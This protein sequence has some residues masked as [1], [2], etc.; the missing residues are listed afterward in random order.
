MISHELNVITAIWTTKADSDFFHYMSN[1]LSY[2]NI[3]SISSKLSRP[4]DLHQHL[5]SSIDRYDF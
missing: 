2:K 1:F 5:I 3:G 4:I